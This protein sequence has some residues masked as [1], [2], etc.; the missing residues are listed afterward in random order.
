MTKNGWLYDFITINF[1]TYFR[2]GKLSNQLSIITL[3]LQNERGLAELY[4]AYSQTFENRDFW[5]NLSK[6]EESHSQFLIAL[7][8]NPDVPPIDKDAIDVARFTN[9]L[10]SIEHDINN[11][12]NITVQ[13]ALERAIYYE[14][15]VLERNVFDLFA[16]KNSSSILKVIERLRDETN[17]HRES[18]IQELAKYS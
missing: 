14:E 8:E 13:K 2:E 12:A 16:T 11:A 7:Y 9:I 6:D 10:D 5:A 4:F 1:I 17:E 18:L 3:L 15:V